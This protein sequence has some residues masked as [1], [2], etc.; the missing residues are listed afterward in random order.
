MLRP[1]PGGT[2]VW[3][4]L[5]G[6]MEW[7]SSAGQPGLGAPTATVAI[8]GS[9]HFAW[10]GV[11]DATPKIPISSGHT[12][13]SVAQITLTGVTPE[14]VSSWQF[15]MRETGRFFM[16][17]LDSVTNPV[18]GGANS[19]TAADFSFR[20]GRVYMTPRGRR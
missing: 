1:D 13:A 14:Y 16:V 11:F 19:T 7:R 5:E 18:N 15:G 8:A 6:E 2:T 3:S 10:R 20:G 17:K 12:E 4:A 9:S